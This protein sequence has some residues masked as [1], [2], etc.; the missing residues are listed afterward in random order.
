MGLV[1]FIIRKDPSV[2]GLQIVNHTKYLSL[3]LND[4]VI[5][6]PGTVMIGVIFRK[7]KQFLNVAFIKLGALIRKM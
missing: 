2:A 5:P 7:A 6:P 1:G 4:S 3:V